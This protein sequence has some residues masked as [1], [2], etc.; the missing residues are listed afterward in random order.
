MSASHA[1]NGLARDP[2]ATKNIDARLA[3]RC[4]DR[5]EWINILLYSSTQ[6]RSFPDMRKCGFDD[7]K[8]ATRQTSPHFSSFCHHFPLTL[9]LGHT[10][11]RSH[12]PAMEQSRYGYSN[13]FVLSCSI[14]WELSPHSAFS[15]KKQLAREKVFKVNQLRIAFNERVWPLLKRELDV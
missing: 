9:S 15:K 7:H 1:R 14:A 6:R 12:G 13:A 10:Y 5:T 8:V 3:W 4:G 2:A 11:L